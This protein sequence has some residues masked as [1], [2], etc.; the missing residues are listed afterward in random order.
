MKYW[1]FT[2]LMA[3]FLL[4]PSFA[5]ALSC[6]AIALHD[7]IAINDSRNIVSKGTIIDNL[8]IVMAYKEDYY[9]TLCQ[10]NGYCYLY[11][12]DIVG[13]ELNAEGTPSKI[14]Q[15]KAP[16][17][18]LLNCKLVHVASNDDANQ[19]EPVYDLQPIP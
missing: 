5:Q 8:S 15:T 13:G 7:T 11:T 3:V 2:G 19:G 12:L 4:S 14:I 6:K 18:K 9:E 1:V 16:A 10:A 17:L